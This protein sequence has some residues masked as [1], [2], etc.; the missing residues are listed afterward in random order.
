MK[1]ASS[2]RMDMQESQ[3]SRLNDIIMSGIIRMQSIMDTHRASI[4]MQDD[5]IRSWFE[6]VDS[7]DRDKNSCLAS[8]LVQKESNWDG[9]LNSYNVPQNFSDIL[10]FYKMKGMVTPQEW[11]LCIGT[12][13]YAHDPRAFQPSKEDALNAGA[14]LCLCQNGGR[15]RCLKRDCKR[16]SEKC[17]TCKRQ[18]RE[19]VSFLYLSLIDQ[20]KS[21]CQSEVYCHDFLTMW[22]DKDKW[23]GKQVS[24]YPKRIHEVWH[25]EKVRLYQEFWDPDSFWQAPVV[26]PNVNCKMAYRAFPET[27]ASKELLS[28]WDAEEEVYEF[29]CTK[30]NE[31]IHEEPKF[32]Q[33]DPR[34]FSF[35]LHWD[36]FQAA[37]TTLKNSAVVEIVVL[38]GG[39][40]SKIGSIPV[41][42]L[43]LSNKELEKKHG[44]ILSAFLQP[45]I[46][47]LENMYL[48]GIEMDFVYPK[49]K[50]HES[51]PS[52]RSILRGILMMCTEKRNVE[53][54]WTAI[55]KAKRCSTREAKDKTLQEA[56]LSGQS[57]LWRLYH[58]Y[59]F[60]ISK[61]LV[62]DTM[63]VLSLNLFQKYVKKMMST[64][65]TNMKKE[66]DNALKA[67]TRA[68]PKTIVN[69]GRW[70]RNPSKHY[71][72]FKAEECQKFVQWCLPHVLNV[73]N[74]ISAENIQ[75]GMLLVDVAHLFFS[76]SRRRGWTAEDIKMGRSLLASWRILSEEYDGPNSSPLEHVAGS[77]ELFDDILRH[78]S[79]DCFWCFV[80]ERCVSGY[81]GIPTNNKANEIS[82]TNFHSRMLFT[83][84]WRQLE[85]EKDGLYCVDKF[86][87]FF[88]SCLILPKGY[89]VV[90]P[91][92]VGCLDWHSQCA[93]LVTSEKQA[94]ELWGARLNLFSCACKSLIE[95]KGIV[96][97]RKWRKKPFFLSL[98][99]I[100]AF[101]ESYGDYVVFARD[102][103]SNGYGKLTKI[104]SHEQAGKVNIVVRIDAILGT[105][106]CIDEVSGMYMMHKDQKDN[107]KSVIL[108]VNCILHKF[109]LLPGDSDDMLVLYEMNGHK[110]RRRLALQDKIGCIPPWLEK[111]DRV[112][113][114]V[115]ETTT[116]QVFVQDV[117]YMHEKALLCC[118]ENGL[119][120]G[121]AFW[122]EWRYIY[123]LL[124]NED[125]ETD[126][127]TDMDD[128]GTSIDN[129][130]EGDRDMDMLNILEVIYILYFWN[131]LNWLDSFDSVRS[132]R[133]RVRVILELLETE[134]GSIAWYTWNVQGC[135]NLFHFS[136][137]V[138][139]HVPLLKVMMFNSFTELEGKIAD[140]LAEETGSEDATS[141]SFAIA[142]QPK[143]GT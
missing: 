54:M 137:I 85:Q 64:A 107:V 124:P 132:P 25:G 101:K 105:F 142:P 9:S 94:K 58:L 79:H 57:I 91:Q 37:S 51:L 59:G 96:I 28:G 30:C 111:S 31:K 1:A 129:E 17:P 15:P 115:T 138:Q 29:F 70:P 66:I 78:G 136:R 65:S 93:F 75:L 10:K 61:D 141:A 83:K 109:F 87:E 117:D 43:P 104:F 103:D 106:N 24:D 108:Y 39:K 84:L 139:K 2:S 32:V 71:K 74:G 114:R 16:C 27:L 80:F 99:E 53:D 121:E 68:I 135:E 63:H 81:L 4:K 76:C 18:R 88:H 62:Y 7:R 40:E 6:G 123:P 56:G 73:V 122:V 34:N 69:A 52:G 128:A 113:A 26:C 46:L 116:L 110:V 86:L 41:L 92:I 118:E 126:G 98:G 19:M 21:L 13:K 50:I 127:D 102:K 82:Y 3:D 140:A 42:F 36:G 77:G 8:L 20:L 22:R 23:L 112:R 48:E 90:D 89:H 100:D 130:D 11:K 97:G 131:R 49:D 95:E 47:E 60:D 45:L 5:M 125:I 35:L 133:K 119:P 38:N 67:V 14:L 44:D 33:G 12:E 55:R 120:Q 72:M 143:G 134:A